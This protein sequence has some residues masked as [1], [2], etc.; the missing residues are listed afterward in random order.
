MHPSGAAHSSDLTTIHFEHPSVRA[1]ILTAA[2][3]VA[4]KPFLAIGSW[5]PLLPWPFR[6]LNL[7]AIMLPP[8]RRIHREPVQLPSARAE[9]FIPEHAD[10][11]RVI[12][13]LHGGGF[14]SCG[15]NTHRRVVSRLSRATRLPV[16]SVEYRKPP[17]YGM[18]QTVADCLDGWDLL[19]GQGYRPGN[20]VLAG[21]SAGAFLA[22]ATTLRLIDRGHGVPGGLLCWSP[23]VDLYTT[24]TAI[25]GAGDPLF[26]A[27]AMNAMARIAVRAES[28]T[29]GARLPEPLSADLSAFPPVLIQT[30]SGEVIAPDSVALGK[31]LAGS[32]VPTTLELWDGQI[33]V[34]PAFAEFGPEGRVAIER[35]A[36]FVQSLPRADIRDTAASA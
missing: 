19:I 36:R 33:H 5:A 32:G 4:V 34:F 2:A 11:D 13:Y 9:R 1:R 7:A 17:R 22:M 23:I 14:V 26:P 27:A 16:L 12:L 18:S 28:R 25:K 29:T 21:D 24:K 10:T 3:R 31:R 15:L 6:V 35:A 30:G 8:M 20:I